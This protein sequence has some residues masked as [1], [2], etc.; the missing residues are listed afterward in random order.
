MKSYNSALAIVQKFG[1]SW[2]MDE[3]VQQILD[4]DIHLQRQLYAGWPESW[5]QVRWPI[6]AVRALLLI[7]HGYGRTPGE[8]ADVLKVSRTNVTGILDR[9]ENDKLIT[10]SIDPNDRRSFTLALTE[11]GRELVREIDSLRRDQLEQAL[12]LMDADSRQ[13][14][15]VGLQAL[16]RAMDVRKTEMIAKG[17]V[18]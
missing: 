4:L 1:L 9:L 3:I 16:T 17:M 6:G 14:L 10:R 5:V 7:E 12:A 13:A 8:V 15:Y 18:E 2:L 11:A